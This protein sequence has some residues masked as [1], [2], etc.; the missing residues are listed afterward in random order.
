MGTSG[1]LIDHSCSKV[2][3]LF[4]EFDSDVYTQSQKK[5]ILMRSMI[6]VQTLPCKSTKAMELMM[7]DKD[8]YVR[9]TPVHKPRHRG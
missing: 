3:I 5:L 6:I 4:N 7:I 1:D 8:M 2:P 9:K